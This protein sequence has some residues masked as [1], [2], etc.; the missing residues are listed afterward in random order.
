M[1]SYVSDY[2]NIRHPHIIPNI[3][4]FNIFKIF[5]ASYLFKPDPTS[6]NLINR[7]L[8]RATR[9]GVKCETVPNIG[10]PT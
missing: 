4:H 6:P 2:T 1:T 3:L 8:R 9:S 5:H 10:C 7:V